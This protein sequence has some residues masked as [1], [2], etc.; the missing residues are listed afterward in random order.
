M[1]SIGSRHLASESATESL[2]ADLAGT[3]LAG[4]VICLIG[5]L[6]AGKTS[7]ARAF[8]RALTVPDQEVP[9]P[10]FTIVQTYD[11]GESPDLL[12]IWH[13]DLYRLSDPEEAGELGIEDAFAD[14]V[15]LIE[16][17]DRVPGLVPAKRLEIHFAFCDKSD[18][19]LVRFRG[20]DSWLDRLRE[21]RFA[22][23]S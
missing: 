9:S 6:G 4:D 16:W 5:D 1:I 13:V 20:D 23:T 10:T 3:I 22:G 12:E 21:R 8:I 15:V 17:P 18:Q 2:A 14:A 19:R 11:A 7:F